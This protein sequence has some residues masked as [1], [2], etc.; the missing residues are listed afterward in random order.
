MN[1]K[2]LKEVPNNRKAVAPY[3]FV[4]LPEKIVLAEPLP[5]GDRYYLDRHTGQIKCTLTTKS[6][7]YIRCGLTPDDF[8]S[9]GDASNEDLTSEQRQKNAEFFQH[10]NSSKP[11]LPGS[12]IRGMLRTLVEIV[13]FGKI[14]QVS[15]Q[16]KFFFRAVAAD[17]KDP[18]KKPYENKLKNIKAGYVVK[19]KD[20]WYIRPAQLINGQSYHKVR[21]KDIIANL[22]SLIRMRQDNYIPQEIQITFTTENSQI[23][24]S[25][26]EAQELD[27]RGW[28]MTS[29]N[30]LENMLNKTEEERGKLLDR[31]AGRKYHYIVAEV[32]QESELLEISSEAIQDYRSA[33]TSFQQGK[34][35]QFKDNP[36][37]YFD[38]KWGI[39]QDEKLIFYCE[40]EVDNP[41]IFFGHSPNF[42]IPYIP[43]SK[44]QAA[45]A[46]DFI[47]DDVGKS[48]KIDLADAIFGFVRDGKNKKENNNLDVNKDEKQ[49]SR[50]GRLS[51]SDAHYVDNEDGMWLTDDVITPQILASPKPTNF[52]HYLVQT[53]PEKQNLK[54]YGSEPNKDTVIRGHKLYWH[55]GNIKADEIQTKDSPEE[56]KNKQSQY[57]EIKPIQSGVSFEL[58]LHFENLSDVELGALLWVLNLASDDKNRLKLLNLDSK[59]QYCFSL[60]MGKPLGMGAVAVTKLELFLNNRKQRSTQLFEQNEDNWETGYSH[61][62][63]NDEQYTHCL[64]DFEKYIISNIQEADLP[65]NCTDRNSLKLKDI[66]RIQMHL[67]LLSWEYPPTSETRY[68]EIEKQNN[69]DTVNEYKDRPILPTPLQVKQIE[70]QRKIDQP[71]HQSRN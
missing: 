24:V 6:P 22:P 37:N 27:R 10:P 1:P 60:G 67:A 9:F 61:C 36:Q 19:A 51:V 3:N 63:A 21:E 46:V 23:E 62:P 38:E 48:D 59:E 7:L 70:D 25:E 55:K 66:P 49:Q 58:T 35:K 57:T 33:L 45:T 29:G 28:L 17:Q 56:I 13:G 44:T 32:D 14:E 4:E 69:N 26:S 50:A 31:K 34:D 54:H 16:Q 71:N 64:Q 68:M 18:L 65:E 2:H 53:D 15:D 12:S 42:R 11:I 20:K 43:P 47:P 39:L 52:Q 5:D 41:V 40:P 8:S 30:M